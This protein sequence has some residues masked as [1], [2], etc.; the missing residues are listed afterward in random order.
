MQSIPEFFAK[1]E[2]IT[3]FVAEKQYDIVVVGAG[4]PGVPA[5]LRAAEL[6][7]KV[8]VLQKEDQAAAC[9]NVS[10]GIL[11]D[12]S[13]LADVA[14]VV[15]LLMEESQHK[16]DREVVKTW[17][18]NSGEA[19]TWLI[20]QAQKAGCQV[21]NL[22][23]GPHAGFKKKQGLDLEWATCLFGPKPYN[24]G[25]AMQD[26]A[27]YAATQ[28]VDF[29]YSTPACQLL[30]DGSGRVVGVAASSP[31]GMPSSSPPRA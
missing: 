13:D 9:G 21:V 11:L 27:R 17:A 28:G 29:Y 12:K 22:G 24:T 25:L 16:A 5:A 2:P 1:P 31:Q 23:N 8:A 10:A 3:E 19:I 6:G 14:K 7:A 15:E 4:S 20:G 18:Y 30:Q 26:L